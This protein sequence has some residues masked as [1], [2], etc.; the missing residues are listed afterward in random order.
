MNK[1]AIIALT[2]G[3]SDL[4]RHIWEAYPEGADLYLPKKFLRPGEKDVRA[5]S[6]DL[7]TV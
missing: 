7:A 1:L 2:R 5:L 6:D 3:G 4:A